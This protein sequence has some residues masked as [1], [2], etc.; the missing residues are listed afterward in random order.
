[1]L[2]ALLLLLLT[3][4][5]P[6]TDHSACS[7][8]SFSTS[9]MSLFAPRSRDSCRGTREGCGEQ[10]GGQR[11]RCR[12][13]GCWALALGCGCGCVGAGCVGRE[14]RDRQRA[15]CPCSP[16]V[17]RGG[18]V[19]LGQLPAA[20][21]WF[22]P[23]SAMRAAAY[24]AGGLTGRGVQP[25][26]RPPSSIPAAKLHVATEAPAKEERFPLVLV[27]FSF[28]VGRGCGSWAA[29]STW[30]G[31]WSPWLSVCRLAA[32]GSERQPR[33]VRSL[34]DEKRTLGT[35]LVGIAVISRCPNTLQK[36]RN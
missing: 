15:V 9:L 19:R 16:A 20:L 32:K 26:G 11:P 24:P 7:S 23:V 10:W 8:S 30:P 25:P 4:L 33:V 18:E 1:M 35:D 14:G 28:S 2:S 6:R 5:S 3:V 13:L 12:G 21:P 34:A 29:S 31:S 17:A 22:C 27:G 36:L